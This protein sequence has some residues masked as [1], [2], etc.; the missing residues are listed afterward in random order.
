MDQQIQPARP[1]ADEAE[2]WR[3]V[4]E[5]LRRLRKANGISR[6]QLAEAIR[7]PADITAQPLPSFQAVLQAITQTS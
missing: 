5:R 1:A 2:T 6:R 4:A 7:Q 3:R